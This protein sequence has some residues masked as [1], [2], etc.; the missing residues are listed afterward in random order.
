MSQTF[1]SKPCYIFA[2]RPRLCFYEDC[3][4]L[5]PAHSGCLV[6]LVAGSGG[7]GSGTAASNGGNAG[8]GDANL[9]FLSPLSRDTM[10]TFIVGKGGTGWSKGKDGTPGGDTIFSQTEKTG[11]L[12]NHFRIQGGHAGKGAGNPVETYNC[13]FCCP[14]EHGRNGYVALY[15]PS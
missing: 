15:F 10:C 7:G 2:H 6:E 12:L 11:E 8:K 5:L 3:Q 9:I 13:E 1:N 4:Y 14:G